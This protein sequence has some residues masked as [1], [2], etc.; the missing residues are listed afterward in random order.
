MLVV[1]LLGLVLPGTAHAASLTLRPE[2]GVARHAQAVAF[3]GELAPAQAGVPVGLYVQ[4][5][6]T[7][8]LVGTGATQA[9]GRYRIR[10]AVR[11]AGTYYAVAQLDAATQVASPQAELRLR[12]TLTVRVRGHRRIGER[13]VLSGHL[14]PA[15]AGRLTYRE[16]S[17]TRR[18]GVRPDG[19]FSAPLGAALPGRLAITVALLPRPG[20]E[21]ARRRVS[22]R[23]RS[24]ALGLG[25]S[26]NAV[27][28]LEARLRELHYV[29]RGVD[30]Y[31]GSDTYAA[32]LAF[33]KVHGLARTG[34]ARGD[35][36]RQLASAHVPRAFVPSGTHL[37]I[38][39]RKQV[40]FEVVD[41]RVARA[42][43][44]STGATGNTPVGRWRV[45]RLGPG[46]NALGMY[47]SLYFLRGFAIHGYRSVPPWPASHGC[48]RTPLWF[49]RGFYAR[50][51]RLGT[52]VFVFP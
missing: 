32:V 29:V 6:P 35:F 22:V 12:P 8:S 3:T 42:I 52:R 26:G 30:R 48:V 50:W 46:F 9:D 51:A 40:M 17:R 27:R 7:W 36:W 38:S 1:G 11:A 25:S 10:L 20:Y 37:E 2:P 43:H 24:V 39:K 4:A 34:R 13:L 23:V 44:V 41:G 47:Y 33:Q 49:A 19:S 28:A 5:G 16:G 14:L 21:R 15:T 45:Y 31:Y 18:L